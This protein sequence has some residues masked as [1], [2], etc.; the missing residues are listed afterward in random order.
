ML[1]DLRRNEERGAIS[2]LIVHPI[3]MYLC[4][5]FAG[6]TRILDFIAKRRSA[7]MTEVLD[8][9]RARAS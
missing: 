4:D 8:R 5:R 6:A 3:T 1:A 2:N 7:R 9:E